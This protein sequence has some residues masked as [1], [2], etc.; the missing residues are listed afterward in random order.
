MTPVFI[1][2]LKEWLE[3]YSRYTLTGISAVIAFSAVIYTGRPESCLTVLFICFVIMGYQTGREKWHKVKLEEWLSGI[4]LSILPVITGKIAGI[5]VI[6][7]IHI[8]VLLP[9]WLFMHVV[10]GIKLVSFIMIFPALL[11]GLAASACL[12]LSGDMLSHINEDS[13]IYEKDSFMRRF[14]IALWLILTVIVPVF[15]PACPL[16]QIMNFSLRKDYINNL[17]SLTAGFGV[18]ILFFFITVLIFHIKDT[19]VKPSAAIDQKTIDD[20]YKDLT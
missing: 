1:S 17:I 5:I 7:L 6:G 8:I 4:K 18:S 16:F 19:S 11:S 13:L 2:E 15:R 14:L 20:Y 10:W 9:L 3:N 12:T